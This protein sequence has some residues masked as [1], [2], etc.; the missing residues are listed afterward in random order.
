[1]VDTLC[2][3]FG[4]VKLGLECPFGSDGREGVE[5]FVDEV[6]RDFYFATE[7]EVE[8]LATFD[9]VEIYPELWFGHKYILS[10]LPRARFAR[11]VEVAIE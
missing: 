9:F 8:V 1:M 2:Y 10:A 3:V 7:A 6:G 11:K 5:A 4:R